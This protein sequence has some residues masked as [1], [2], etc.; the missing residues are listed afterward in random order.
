VSTI[1]E[2]INPENFEKLL[3]MQ[4]GERGIASFLGENPQAVYWTFCRT[5]GH[6]RYVFKE[7][8][9]GTRYV[10]DFVILNSYSGLWEVMFIELEPVDDLT[11]NKSGTP[12]KRFL[13][14]LKQVDDWVE[15]FDEHKLQIRSDLVRWAQ[16]KD[17]LGYSDP[18]FVCNDSGDYLVDPS[19]TIWE[20]FHVIIGRRHALSKEGRRR[21]ATYRTKRDVE[22]MSYDRIL[23]M[24]KE[25]YHDPRLWK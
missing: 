14:S 1:S 19:T 9:I 11:F 15:Y 6:T 25:R 18:S 5:G 20:S 7:F 16:T 22:V 2:Y 17:I 21:K 10:A 4:E 24:V 13:G 12:T 23:D 3:D 8:P